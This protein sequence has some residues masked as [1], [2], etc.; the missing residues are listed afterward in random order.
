MNDREMGFTYIKYIFEFN[1][2]KNQ[3]KLS[4]FCPAYII[5]ELDEDM[6]IYG[7]L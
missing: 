6:I 5:S 7:N 1:E 3:I 4:I 2:Q